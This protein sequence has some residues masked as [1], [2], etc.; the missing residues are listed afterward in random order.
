M[1]GRLHS[2][3]GL[4]GP[5]MDMGSGTKKGKK[6]RDGHDALDLSADSGKKTLFDGSKTMGDTGKRM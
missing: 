4:F 2:E 6:Q 5:L 1:I 3:V